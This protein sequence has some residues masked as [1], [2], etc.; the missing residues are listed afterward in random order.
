[1]TILPPVLEEVTVS[2]VYNSGTTI[3]IPPPTG[4]LA[5]ET[6]V[7][8]IL[9]AYTGGTPMTSSM[10]NSMIALG[11]YQN[12]AGSG[13][14]AHTKAYHNNAVSQEGA[15]D[16]VATLSLAT[17]SAG[18]FAMRFGNSNGAESFAAVGY[19]GVTGAQAMPVSTATN[20]DS[21]AVLCVSPGAGVT[22]TVPAGWV[23]FG[24]VWGGSYIFT[25]QLSASGSVGA[26]NITMSGSSGDIFM[27]M[28][29]I[30]P[31]T[32]YKS[33]TVSFGTSASSVSLNVPTGEVGDLL[34]LFVANDVGNTTP[35]HSYTHI[36]A[37][38]QGTTQGCRSTVA[39]KIADGSDGCTLTVTTNDYVAQIIRIP[40]NRHG[41]KNV[42]TDIFVDSIQT[43]SQ[44]TCYMPTLTPGAGVDDYYWFRH[45]AIELNATAS[46]P[47]GSLSG[48]QTASSQRSASS[49]SSVWGYVFAL[50][51]LATTTQSI[52][53]ITNS[54]S[55][56][57]AGITLAIPS[58]KGVSA[59]DLGSDAEPHASSAVADMTRVCT[60]LANS[61]LVVMGAG[62][63]DD[64]AGAWNVSDDIT[65]VGTWTVLRADFLAFGSYLN[66]AFIAYAPV[67]S[68]PEQGTVT[69]T[70]SPSG[71]KDQAMAFS[72]VNLWTPSGAPNFIQSG[73]DVTAG[74][75]SVTL[76][77][78]Q[79]LGAILTVAQDI[80]NGIPAPPSGYAL[81]DQYTHTDGAIVN[82]THLKPTSATVTWGGSFGTDASTTIAAEFAPP[83]VVNATGRVLLGLNYRGVHNKDSSKQVALP[84]G[85]STVAPA[86]KSLS[87]PAAVGI[88]IEGQVIHNKDASLVGM[89]PVGISLHGEIAAYEASVA[90][91]VAL[92]WATGGVAG[93]ETALDAAVGVGIGSGGVS[94]HELPTA[95][96]IGLGIAPASDGGVHDSTPGGIITLG[97]HPSADGGKALSTI[98]AVPVGVAFGGDSGKSLSLESLIGLGIAGGGASVKELLTDSVVALGT[99]ILGISMKELATST[100]IGLGWVVSSPPAADTHTIGWVS[101]GF[102]VEA[103]LT[104]VSSVPALVTVGAH[105]SGMGSKELSLDALVAL[106]WQP[107]YGAYKEHSPSGMIPL[108]VGLGSP[109]FKS[110]LP[111]GLVTL[112]V[113]GSSDFSLDRGTYSSIELGTTVATE[114]ERTT[115]VVSAIPLGLYVATDA[116]KIIESE[117]LIGLGLSIS[118]VQLLERITSGLV[119]IGISS[120]FGFT[121]PPVVG[122]GIQLGTIY[123]PIESVSVYDG[124]QTKTLFVVTEESGTAYP[125]QRFGSNFLEEL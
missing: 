37:S 102:A 70:R 122:D 113:Y 7:A 96:A 74:S 87:T 93:K 48:W 9:A 53:S 118:A 58:N 81:L 59:I 39:G 2:S 62:F 107:S 111:V 119:V 63:V 18:G 6:V 27:S 5:A 29:I 1:M 77:T 43:A 79:T 109:I 85:I 56:N 112:G 67:G 61:T 34:L 121:D 8:Y 40:R 80:F 16:F 110:A 78:L 103:I 75:G 101:M 86:S 83:Y 76:S 115:Y 4:T 123:L 36:W 108:G 92:G 82:A 31:G 125:Y 114:Y 12:L 44:T 21:L 14:T 20:I 64:V 91:L 19:A 51:S 55:T 117:A 65:A 49:T 90:A 33:G 104:K 66:S 106:G 97:V 3:S 124:V 15:N 10:D 30:K 24:G 42:A 52:A 45:L 22:F 11:V 35:S 25:K 116:T 32:M 105:P 23:Q 54:Q 94:I 28:F 71:T 13:Y 26:A 17:I 84:V 73:T 60:P 88:G 50:D 57:S 38:I 89:V 95:A 68:S 100:S 98:G 41:V 69:V 47:S 99:S 46:F 120:G 72:L